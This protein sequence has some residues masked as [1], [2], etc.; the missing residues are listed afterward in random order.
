MTGFSIG[1]LGISIGVK[2]DILGDRN[3][4]T[5]ADIEGAKGVIELRRP[6]GATKELTQTTVQVEEAQFIV[7]GYDDRPGNL[8]GLP[9]AQ[10]PIFDM[11][12]WWEKGARLE[13]PDG[14]VYRVSRNERIM[15]AVS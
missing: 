12:G 10:T 6:D 9:V 11:A 3:T 13:W 15:I 14:R 5:E 7:I 8:L 1:Q 4:L 2:I